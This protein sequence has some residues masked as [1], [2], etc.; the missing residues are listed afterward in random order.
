MGFHVWK[1]L[2]VSVEKRMY[3][4][5]TVLSPYEVIDAVA[6]IKEADPRAIINH[7]K[8]MVDSIGSQNKEEFNWRDI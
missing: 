6:V 1:P 7:R 3:L 5:H 4:L 8:L 2:V